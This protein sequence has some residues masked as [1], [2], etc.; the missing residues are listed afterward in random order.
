MNWHILKGFHYSTFFPWIYNLKN[1]DEF[2]YTVEFTNSCRYSIDEESCVNK[3]FGFCFGLFGVHKNSIRFGWTYNNINQNIDI[4]KYC[5]INGKLN[6]QKIS[7][8]EIGEKAEF[9]IKIQIINNNKQNIF[10]IKNDQCLSSQ[11]YKEQSKWLFSLGPYF[12]GNT[13]AP[14]HITIKKY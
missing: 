5:Y 9:K 10:L 4:W 11:L 1:K 3:L 12:G 2:T 7:N 14:Q 8:V 6:K 13:R